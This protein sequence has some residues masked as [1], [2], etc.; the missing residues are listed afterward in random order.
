MRFINSSHETWGCLLL[1]RTYKTN[2]LNNLETI[3]LKSRI[4]ERK[5]GLDY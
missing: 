3:I 1:E 4:K 2:E 5:G